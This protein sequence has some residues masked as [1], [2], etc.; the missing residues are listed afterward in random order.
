[1][2]KTSLYAGIYYIISA[3]IL[4]KYDEQFFSKGFSTDNV[5]YRSQLTTKKVPR[6]IFGH[7]CTQRAQ[8]GT[9][10]YRL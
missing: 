4:E 5:R 3:V 8:S 2:L 1:M 10:G 7:F 6:K 9:P